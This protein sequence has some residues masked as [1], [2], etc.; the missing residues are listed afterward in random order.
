MVVLY[1][2]KTLVKFHANR[3]L[4]TIQSLNLFFMYN[5]LETLPLLPLSL[6]SHDAHGRQIHQLQL[7]L[8]LQSPLLSCACGHA[9][10][11]SF[12]MLLVLDYIIIRKNKKNFIHIIIKDVN[13]L[14]TKS[15]PYSRL[16][17]LYIYI[18]IYI[19]TKA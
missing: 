14:K 16:R 5:F 11:L 9:L 13:K 4:F 6:S 15:V 1:I 18:Y 19:I 12:P 17:R 2:L 3:T 10:D 8:L 7:Q